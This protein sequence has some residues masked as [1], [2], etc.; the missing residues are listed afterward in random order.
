[1]FF[2][3]WVIAQRR[4]QRCPPHEGQHAVRTANV[5]GSPPSKTRS[6][7]AS[8]VQKPRRSRPEPRDGYRPRRSR[9]RSVPSAARPRAPAGGSPGHT[10]QEIAHFA[11]GEALREALDQDSARI[12]QRDHHRRQRLA[13]QKGGR[14]RLFRDCARSRRQAP[15]RPERHMPSTRSWQGPA[16]P[17]ARGRGWTPDQAIR[18]PAGRRSG[19]H[20]I[21]MSSGA[22]TRVNQ[23]LGVWT[24][25][26]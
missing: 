21:W 5:L 23:A 15:Q 13:E 12:H 16:V 8:G 4:I 26:E 24:G 20:E 25:L 2:F 7:R 22:Y 18:G 1:M 9:R 3:G 6:A 19:D 11:P 10:R 14:P 17:K